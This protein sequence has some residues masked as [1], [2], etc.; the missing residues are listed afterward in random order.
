MIHAEPVAATQLWWR[1]KLGSPGRKQTMF[2]SKQTARLERGGPFLFL[3]LVLN[4]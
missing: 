2:K 1:P 3:H 4:S